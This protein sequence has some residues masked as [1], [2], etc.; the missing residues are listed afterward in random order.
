LPTTKNAAKGKTVPI[1]GVN[2][3]SAERHARLSGQLTAEHT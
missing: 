3:S 1:V 2:D